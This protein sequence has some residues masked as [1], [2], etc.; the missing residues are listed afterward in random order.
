MTA[1]S[2]PSH[3]QTS[4]SGSTVASSA[5]KAPGATSMYSAPASSAPVL[6]W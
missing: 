4:R 2:E 1:V 5:S 6:A 3:G